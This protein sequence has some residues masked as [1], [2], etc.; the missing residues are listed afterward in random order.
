[1]K[2]SNGTLLANLLIVFTLAGCERA[3]T[4]SEPKSRATLARYYGDRVT[5]RQEISANGVV[6]GYAYVPDAITDFA[7]LVEDSSLSL[8]SDHP[9]RFDRCGPEFVTPRLVG[10]VAD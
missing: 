8:F 6:C 10:P 1:M 2:P 9:E 7:F 4:I 5:V 3:A